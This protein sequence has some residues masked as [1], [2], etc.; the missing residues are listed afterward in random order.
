MARS[1]DKDQKANRPGGFDKSTEVELRA[2]DVEAW[3]PW[4]DTSV[5]GID[6]VVSKARHYDSFVK[7]NALSI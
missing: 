6:P 1:P 5:R 2:F 7:R 4:S 3:Q